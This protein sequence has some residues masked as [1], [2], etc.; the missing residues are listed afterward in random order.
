[1]RL[2]TLIGTMMHGCCSSQ[3][4]MKT[5]ITYV[6]CIKNPEKTENK[7]HLLFVAV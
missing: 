1:M 7:G 6:N 3:T 2:I 4:V 5:S